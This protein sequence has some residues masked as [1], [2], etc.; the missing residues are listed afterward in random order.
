MKQIY[1]SLKNVNSNV[2]NLS[3][4]SFL[5]IFLLVTL[6][7][8]GMLLK[9]IEGS[10]YSEVYKTYEVLSKYLS[11]LLNIS[12][13]TFASCIFYYFTI[14]LPEEQTKRI[15]FLYIK[16]R[17][18]VLNAQFSLL[19]ESLGIDRDENFNNEVIINA[20][21]HIDEKTKIQGVERIDGEPTYARFFQ[22]IFQIMSEHID[23]IVTTNIVIDN[24]VLYGAL[25]I[26][27]QLIYW[28]ND[29]IEKKAKE[30]KL[31][32]MALFILNIREGINQLNYY[33]D[34][35]NKN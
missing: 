23:K 34:K 18:N 26:H 5:L 25:M 6:E 32:E 4:I 22:Q 28:K 17:I 15:S 27:D 21:W 35:M 16:E 1:N 14:H 2:K 19:I 30:K 29:I 24:E 12:Y 8:I 13:S 3:Y 33:V 20:L 31:S 7:I 11:I 9:P 10:I